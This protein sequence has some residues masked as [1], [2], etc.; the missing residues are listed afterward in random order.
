VAQAILIHSTFALQRATR[1]NVDLS[2]R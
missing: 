1:V 2:L